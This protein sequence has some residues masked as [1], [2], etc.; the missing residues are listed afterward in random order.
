MKARDLRKDDR[1]TDFFHG[2][3]LPRQQILCAADHSVGSLSQ[4]L[5]GLVNRRALKDAATDLS[6]RIREASSRHAGVRKQKL[7][8]DV[9]RKAAGK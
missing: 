2:D 3:K 6:T 9:W 4:S 8:A 5:D 1:R 7:V